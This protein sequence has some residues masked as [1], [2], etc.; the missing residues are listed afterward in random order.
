MKQKQVNYEFLVSGQKVFVSATNYHAALEIVAKQVGITFNGTSEYRPDYSRQINDA[1]V[2][3]NASE[4][5]IFHRTK[6][7]QG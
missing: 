5:L 3:I 4:R 6:P 7:Q 1:L 2:Q